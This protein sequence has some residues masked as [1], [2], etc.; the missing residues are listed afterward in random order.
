MHPVIMI[1]RKNI[2]VSKTTLSLKEQPSN[3]LDKRRK[4]FREGKLEKDC[5]V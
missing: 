5:F 2:F 1:E 3:I 4:I